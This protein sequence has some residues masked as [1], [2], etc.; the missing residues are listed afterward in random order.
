MSDL[1]QM[2]AG[3]ESLTGRRQKSAVA[4]MGVPMVK[5]DFEL[6]AII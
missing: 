2:R 1:S 3:A 6:E 4:L 5:V